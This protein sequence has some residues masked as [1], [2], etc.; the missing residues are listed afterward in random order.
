MQPMVHPSEAR[1]DFIVSCNSPPQAI[2][3][4]VGNLVGGIKSKLRNI[5]ELCNLPHIYL[6]K[7]HMTIL[8][9]ITQHNVFENRP[10]VQKLH[11]ASLRKTL[12]PKIL[13]TN[14]FFWKQNDNGG[15]PLAET[16][17]P[18]SNEIDNLHPSEARLHF[19][20]ELKLASA[21][22]SRTCWKFSQGHKIQTKQ[23][24]KVL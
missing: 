17:C 22:H 6:D 7:V 4:H 1:L 14:I 24:N 13:P 11:C 19:Y 16:W 18:G 3:G 10:L 2:Q 23:H 9:T 12:V 20:Y 5:T 15:A 21:R 8:P